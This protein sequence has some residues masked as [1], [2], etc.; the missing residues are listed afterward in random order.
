MIGLSG[1]NATL[2]IPAKSAIAFYDGEFTPCDTACEEPDDGTSTV[3]A[4]FSGYAP[5]SAG[6]DVY[7]VGS[8]AALGGWDTSKAVKLSSSG[9]DGS[10]NVTWESNANRGPT[11]SRC[12]RR[13]T[14]RGAGR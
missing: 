5:T 11:R 12:R 14:R 9:K 8:I 2:T 3:T 7:V 10:G 4:T 1:G 6:Q 13:R